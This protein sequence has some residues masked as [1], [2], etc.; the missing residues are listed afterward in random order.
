MPFSPT[1]AQSIIESLSKTMSVDV[2]SLYQF[3][4]ADSS[5]HLIASS[6]LNK[7]ALGTKLAI[8]QGLTGKVARDRKPLAVK[9]PHEHPDYFYIQGSGEEQYQSFLGIPLIK[10]QSLFGVLVVQ[11]KQSQMF[12][13]SDIKAL[14]E[15]GRSVMLE[16]SAEIAHSNENTLQMQ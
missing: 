2:C 7:T 15:A 4:E 13:H 12:F 16:L 10:A 8:H 6:G 3:Q 1:K 5:L 9:Q 14:Y 11:T